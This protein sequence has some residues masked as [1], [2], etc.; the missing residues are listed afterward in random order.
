MIAVSFFQTLLAVTVFVTFIASMVA[1]AGWVMGA[2]DRGRNPYFVL[3]VSVVGVVALTSVFL[4]LG[5][6]PLNGN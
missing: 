2:I 3:V 5:S 6:G 1:L 4:W